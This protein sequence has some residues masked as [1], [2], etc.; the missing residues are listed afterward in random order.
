MIINATPVNTNDINHGL[1]LLRNSPY[2]FYPT[3]SRVFNSI[4]KPSTDY[5][6]FTG[7]ESIPFFKDNGYTLMK[8]TSYHDQNTHSVY[9]RTYNHTHIDVQ[10]VIDLRMKL[11]VQKILLNHY[12]FVNSLS[13][14]GRSKLWIIAN[15]MFIEGVKSE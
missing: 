3:G 1:E 9:S 10:V 8:D 6:F 5:D 13:K 2:T 4:V 14:I 15:D 12:N 7:M 11:V